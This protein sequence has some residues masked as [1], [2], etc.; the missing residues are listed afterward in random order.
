[1]RRLEPQVAIGVMQVA[2][3]GAGIE[4][5]DKVLREV[6]QSIH[7]QILP[8]EPN[9]PPFG[10]AKSGADDIDINQIGWVAAIA[11]KEPYLAPQEIAICYGNAA[12]QAL[13][14]VGILLIIGF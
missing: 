7:L 10:G 12:T 13:V 1:V 9:R 8:A 14:T 11:S 2:N 6:C 5:G 3:D 4:Q